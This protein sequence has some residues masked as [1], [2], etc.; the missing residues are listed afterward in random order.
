[1]KRT[2]LLVC[3]VFVLVIG[4][5]Y[6]LDFE[7]KAEAEYNIVTG[8]MV[9]DGHFY[10]E[11][12]KRFAEIVADRTDGRV[13]IDIYAGAVLGSEEEIWENIQA[14]S[15]DAGVVAGM[16]AGKFVAEQSFYGLPFLF[17]NFEHRDAFMNSEGHEMMNQRLEEKGNMISLAALGG[18]TRV[19]I[20]PEIKVETLEDI[21][22]IDMR[23]WSPVV[24]DTWEALGTNTVT[25]DFGEIYT[26]LQTAAVDAV[27]QCHEDLYLEGWY[28]QIDYLTRTNH[29]ITLRHLLI[30]ADQFYSLP[31]DIQEI[32]I[33]AGKEAEVYQAELGRERM[34]E[35]EEYFI[36]NGVEMVDL[37]DKERWIEA[38]AT[39]RDSF[40]EEH[41]LEEIYEI[42]QELAN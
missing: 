35:H 30:G 34:Q 38:T 13:N 7:A 31:E 1:M 12:V 29:N 3:L 28:E 21:Q 27:D 20:T 32:L 14:G 37:Q 42:V 19:L 41:G 23:V 17:E 9:S 11:G 8:V 39:I 15:V 5:G 16:Q 40:I 22:G 33:E 18:E 2:I 36:E 10:T 4:S 6:I 26:A 24:N 25:V